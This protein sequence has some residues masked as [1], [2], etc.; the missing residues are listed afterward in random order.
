M[1]L[2]R[3]WWYCISIGEYLQEYVTEMHPFSAI[4]VEDKRVVTL[5]NWKQ[6][7][8]EEYNLWLDLNKK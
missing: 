4:K 8:V 6:I 5:V 7:S 2:K 3:Y 1:E